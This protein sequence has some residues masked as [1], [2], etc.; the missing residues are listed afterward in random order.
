MDSPPRI[1]IR[2]DIPPPLV[3]SRAR[4]NPYSVAPPPKKIRRLNDIFDEYI[5]IDSSIL[6]T[7]LNDYRGNPNTMLKLLIDTCIEN[8]NKITFNEELVYMFNTLF[9]TGA[10]ITDDLID[11]L[12]STPTI[13]EQYDR[14]SVFFSDPGFKGSVGKGIV[15]DAISHKISSNKYIDSYKFIQAKRWQDSSR[16]TSF[17]LL[18][19]MDLK[20]NSA[21][22]KTL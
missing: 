6:S 4:F 13:P 17:D 5:D 21:F 16:D 8:G 20:Y 2:R 14:Y 22:L 19:R 15:I 10:V 12:F 18:Y 9:E 11:L 3:R 1:P 7:F